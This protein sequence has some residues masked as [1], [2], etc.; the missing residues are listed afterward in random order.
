MID[1]RL[2]SDF[3]QQAPFQPATNLWRAIEISK[4][5][6][7]PFPTGR[8][9]DL[10]C[11]DGKLT[12]VILE[13]VG[14][15][16]LVGIDLDPEE[17]ALAKATGIY[18]AIHTGSAANIPEPSGSFDFI[19]SNSVLE[20]IPNIHEVL[21][22]AS[23][24]LKTDG[25]LLFTVPSQGFHK[26]LKGPTNQTLREAYLKEIDNRCAHI[27]YWNKTEWEKALQPLGLR[28]VICTEYMNNHET[29]RWEILS[30][31][32]AGI[33]YRLTGMKRQPIDMQRSLG[34]RRHYVRLHP[35]FA[36]PI[37]R[38]LSLGLQSNA[39]SDDNSCLMILALRTQ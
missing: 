24:L 17:T 13:R 7:Q 15:R 11:G 36:R 10:G 14:H 38:I 22:E 26:N 9:L 25:K 37:A 20:H 29:K 21:N 39:Q 27:R 2:F 1:Q 19:F 31:M 30:N 33:L 16:E 35:V 4:V 34:M 5:L 12:Q 18:S 8:G 28:I 32:T 3:L 23:R 6:S